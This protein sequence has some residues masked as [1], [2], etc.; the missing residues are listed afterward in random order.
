MDGKPLVDQKN[1]SRQEGL[2]EPGAGVVRHP[3]W[4][5]EL[6][7]TT[8]RRGTTAGPAGDDAARGCPQL[9]PSAG[10]KGSGRSTRRF[11]TILPPTERA[12]LAALNTPP[13]P[14]ADVASSSSTAPYRAP[15]EGATPG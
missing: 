8:T 11:Y 5:D 10:P 12:R 9:T 6:Y 7:S 14:A 15:P 4:R 13:R 2:H 1:A 3:L